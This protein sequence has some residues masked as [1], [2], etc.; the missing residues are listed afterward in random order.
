MSVILL[1][2]LIKVLSR[3]PLTHEEIV[4]RR[5]LLSEKG[6]P[7]RTR[8]VSVRYLLLPFVTLSGLS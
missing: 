3:I 4:E 1:N 8:S 6:S 7:E 2:L 5:K